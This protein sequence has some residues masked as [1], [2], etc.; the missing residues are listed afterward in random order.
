MGRPIND[1]KGHKY[2]N[3]T[4]IGVTP[5]LTESGEP[6]W[7][8]RCGCGDTTG[9]A[10]SSSLKRGR[11]NFCPMCT[12]SASKGSPYK[13]LYGNYQRGAKQR[14]LDFEL[15]IKELSALSNQACHYCK[16]PPTQWLKKVGAAYGIKYN[17]I[18]RVVNSKGYTLDNTVPCCKFC[19]FAKGKSTESEFASWLTHI[20]TLIN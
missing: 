2:G 6:L 9:K 1:I 19:N 18:D 17:G 14:G 11:K 5:D 8:L 16:Y 3:L 7:Q 12:L 10:T 15:T 20:R 4:V 13:S